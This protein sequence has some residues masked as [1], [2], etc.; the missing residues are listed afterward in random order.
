MGI[1]AGI[2]SGLM[3]G[4]QGAVGNATSMIGGAIPAA[5]GIW[6]RYRTGVD[7]GLNAIGDQLFQN[8]N[9]AVTQNPFG[10]YGDAWGGM[11]GQN[12][13]GGAMG[14]GEAQANAI[15]QMMGQYPGDRKSVV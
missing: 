1:D 15:R 5:M 14:S 3:S 8:Y 6:D 7:P 2:L 9:Q 4:A 13:W 11:F 12:A 10:S